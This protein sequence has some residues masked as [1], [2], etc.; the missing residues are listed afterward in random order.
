[1]DLVVPQ[2][3]LYLLARALTEPGRRGGE[4]SVHCAHPSMQRQWQTQ[5]GETDKG[6]AHHQ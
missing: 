3:P 2:S 4:Q 6:V 1:M 5:N